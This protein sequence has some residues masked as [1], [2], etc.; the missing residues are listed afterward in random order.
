[1]NSHYHCN[2][3]EWKVHIHGGNGDN[4]PLSIPK[5][6]DKENRGKKNLNRGNSPQTFLRGN[7]P[8]DMSSQK[9]RENSGHSKFTINKLS[10]GNTPQT[11]HLKK[12]AV[13]LSYGDLACGVLTCGTVL[14]HSFRWIKFSTENSKF[15]FFGKDFFVPV[16]LVEH[17]TLSMTK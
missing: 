16:F 14:N 3:W 1:V 9:K 13:N 17:I 2:F 8:F 10:E 5:K 6:N 4:F 15:L 12:S 11:N 7:L